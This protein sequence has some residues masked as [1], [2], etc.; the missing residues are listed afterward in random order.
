M[1][2]CVYHS[3]IPG[4]GQTGKTLRIQDGEA[5][6]YLHRLISAEYAD[7]KG[8]PRSTAFAS[9]YRANDELFYMAEVWAKH[10]GNWLRMG[11][12]HPNS[13]NWQAQ[14]EY[15]ADASMKCYADFVRDYKRQKSRGRVVNAPYRHNIEGT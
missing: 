6:Q 12:A 2:E 4:V 9:R 7:I 3:P 11:E 13:E 15:A 8:A 14:H 5:Y 10:A 1:N